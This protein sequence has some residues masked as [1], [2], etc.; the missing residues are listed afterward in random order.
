MVLVGI[1]GMEITGMA[2]TGDIQI[3]TITE[4]APIIQVEEALL[5]IIQQ[6]APEF[7]EVIIEHKTTLL[8]EELLTKTIDKTMISIEIPLIE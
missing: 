5:I 8:V 3:I 1:I 7:L 6:T 2:T 4:R